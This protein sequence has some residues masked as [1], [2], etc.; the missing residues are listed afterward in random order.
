MGEAPEAFIERTAREN[1]FYR[2]F[3]SGARDLQ[4]TSLPFLTKSAILQDQLAHP[5]LG[6]N[7]G[8][9]RDE[10]KRIHRTSGTSDRPLLIALTAAD[11]RLVIDSGA[12]AFRT[13][14]VSSSDIVVNC[15]NY[16]MW[17]GGF[18]DHL[19]LEAAGACVVPYGVGQTEGLVKLLLSLERPSI[20]ATPSYLS[21]IREVLKDRFGMLPRDLGLSKGFFGGE[22]GL[23]D[24]SFRRSIEQEWGM[25][26]I[27]ANYG[28]S[29]VISIL[30]AECPFRKGLHFTAAPHLY[31]ELIDGDLQTVP[32]CEG[33]RGELVVTTLQKQAQPLIRYR[34]GDVL[35]VL[36]MG[37][38]E[39]GE[40]SF[41][42][43]LV[44]RTD[45][46]L[47]V[48]GINFF[49]ETVRPL[50]CDYPGLTGSFTVVV[51]D[52]DPI[53][54][55]TLVLECSDITQAESI[56]KSIS[57]SLK[58]AL[59]FSPDIEFVERI[60]WVGNKRKLVKRI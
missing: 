34:T 7:L 54:A 16:C 11:E 19:S 1:Q 27:N 9:S 5:P 6:N 42:F 38:C 40:P 55:V 8:I 52:H 58:S 49:P 28:L 12:R 22:S 3:Y 32:L 15:M 36:N 53:E 30:G 50:L 29:E 37:H 31:L 44:G 18:M 33:A 41:T 35:E 2:E 20:H 14:G 56:R 45:D 47:V 60:E 48:K 23:Q 43:N 13:A 17:M 4:Y 59:Y 39:C 57:S 24:E 21:K 10:I 51:E 46:M 26:A 25:S